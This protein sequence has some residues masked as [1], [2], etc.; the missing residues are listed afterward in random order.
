MEGGTGTTMPQLVI[1][2]AGA[3]C[4]GAGRGA[5]PWDGDHGGIDPTVWNGGRLHGT[6]VRQA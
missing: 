4:A 2:L 6:G 1:H 5:T 3:F